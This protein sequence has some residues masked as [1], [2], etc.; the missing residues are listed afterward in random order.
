MRS[1]VVILLAISLSITSFAQKRGN[2][3]TIHLPQKDK[4]RE[5]EQTY[6]IATGLFLADDHKKALGKFY[7][8]EKKQPNNASVKYM[9]SRCLRGMGSHE[10]AL[11]YAEK[12][13]S[14]PESEREF[15]LYTTQLHKHNKD[16]ESAYKVFEKLFN[17][18]KQRQEDYFNLGDIYRAQAKKLQK[19]IQLVALDKKAEKKIKAI[20]NQIIGLFEKEYKLYEE[21]ETLYALNHDVFVRKQGI[22]FILNKK[23][24]A[25]EA[26]I[27]YLKDNQENDKLVHEHCIAFFK[28]LP[29]KTIVLLEEEVRKAPNHIKNNLLLHDLY[30]KNNQ[31]AKAEK[32]ILSIFDNE[33]LSLA[34]KTRITSVYLQNK[35][36]A[37]QVIGNQ[38]LSKIMVQ[39]PEKPQGYSLKG[40]VYYVNGQMDSARLLYLQALNFDTDKKPLWDRVFLISLNQDKQQ[41]LLSDLE[42][43]VNKNKTNP[44][45]TARLGY[46]YAN[47][48][49]YTKAIGFLEEASKSQFSAS[50]IKK[51]LGECYYNTQQYSKAWETYEEVLVKNPNDVNVLNNYSY[52]LAKQ[53]TKLKQAE[54][55]C[56]T[57]MRMNGENP[58]YQDTYAWVLYKLQKYTE[59]KE[60]IEKALV[61]VQD[62]EILAHYG[63]ILK[64]MGD[65]DNA[66][67]QWEKSL[68]LQPNNQL[69]KQKINA[70]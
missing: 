24:K 6:T 68:K 32:I 62:A 26:G 45:Y 39:Y 3:N 40:D 47:D 30:N 59:A 37:S 4:K 35:S 8:I 21:F 22:L 63:D 61:Q 1:I 19:G 18:K 36:N 25:W 65:K 55:M 27:Q 16:Y 60:M 34:E 31:S 33:S 28:F 51:I 9:I 57:L 50:D 49:Q 11:S 10:L 5:L 56:K 2:P 15:F 41:Q 58:A 53:T 66:V 7:S 70:Q 42:M 29:N 67:I 23:E 38:L 52:Y 44:Y 46:A 13:I 54:S 69:L 12:S 48:K 14:F 17:N 43:A 20:E 64:A